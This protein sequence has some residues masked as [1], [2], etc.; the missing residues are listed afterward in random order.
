MALLVAV[1]NITYF[2]FCKSHHKVPEVNPKGSSDLV[3][4]VILMRLSSARRHPGALDGCYLYPYLGGF[5]KSFVDL[6]KITE[7]ALLVLRSSR[8]ITTKL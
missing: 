5:H 1:R 8:A 7:G 6:A 3:V 2:A 4:L